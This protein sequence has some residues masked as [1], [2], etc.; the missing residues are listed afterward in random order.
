MKE[1]F[2]LRLGVS[3]KFKVANKHMI[4]TILQMKISKI[5]QV[6]LR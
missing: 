1:S 4:S 5:I 6:N 3:N 2:L